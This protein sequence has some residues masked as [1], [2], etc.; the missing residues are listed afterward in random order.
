MYALLCG[1]PPFKGDTDDE[2]LNSIKK[3]QLTFPKEEWESVSLLA[4]DLIKRLLTKNPSER[5]SAEEAFNHPWLTENNTIKDNARF[6]MSSLRNMKMFHAKQKLQKASLTYIVNNLISKDKKNTLISLFQQIDINGDGILTREEIINGYKFSMPFEDIESQIDDILNEVD[7]DK[8]G[9]I[10]YSEFVM[11]TLDKKFLLNEEI[12]DN[13]FKMFDRDGGG[14]IS[15]LEI[16]QTLG[17][18]VDYQSISE[19]INEFDLN[20]DGEI[21]FDEF[22]LMMRKLMDKPT[23]IHSRSEK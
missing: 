11:A 19:M 10:D 2:I 8:N 12:L 3:S 22:H 21:S 14:S 7:L 18:A 4:K 23:L 15:L 20:G 17:K 5:I 16:K 1:Y 13:T 6:T 9:T